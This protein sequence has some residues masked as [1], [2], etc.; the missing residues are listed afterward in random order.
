M[1]H[2]ARGCLHDAEVVQ[3]D[4]AAA[5]RRSGHG[6][7][8]PRTGGVVFVVFVMCLCF[9]CYLLLL[10][11]CL[12]FICCLL[13]RAGGGL[14]LRSL[15]TW[16]RLEVLGF[17]GLGSAS[18]GGQDCLAPESFLE[19]KART[20]CR[21]PGKPADSPCQAQ[22]VSKSGLSKLPTEAWSCSTSSCPSSR[23]GR[24]GEWHF[25]TSSIRCPFLGRCQRHC[26]SSLVMLARGTLTIAMPTRAQNGGI[27]QHMRYS[28]ASG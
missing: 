15:G 8:T 17:G 14:E 19:P 20:T 13:P 9:R 4:V 2:V 5:I 16:G 6:F 22:C 12:L 11:V 28:D 25:N 7:P 24:R 21:G 10:V 26:W 23:P 3:P 27:C 18:F 1:L